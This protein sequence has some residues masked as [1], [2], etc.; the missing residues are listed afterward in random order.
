MH[1]TQKHAFCYVTH[2]LIQWIKS[3]K[4]LASRGG[5]G[6]RQHTLFSHLKRI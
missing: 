4:L 6:T 5:L 2:I 3:V 1:R